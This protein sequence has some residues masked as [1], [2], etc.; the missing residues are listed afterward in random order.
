MKS[1]LN[2]KKLIAAFPSFGDEKITKKEANDFL[3]FEMSLMIAKKIYPEVEASEAYKLFTAYEVIGNKL[4]NYDKYLLQQARL[5]LSASKSKKYWQEKLSEY[6]K[7]KYSKIRLF[8]IKDDKIIKKDLTGIIYADREKDYLDYILTYKK[9]S[10]VATAKSK[11]RE[12]IKLSLKELEKNAEEMGEKIG[13]DYFIKVLRDNKI[14]DN[15]SHEVNYININ[16]LVN[17]VGMVGA[18]K[19]TLLKIIV[20]TLN[21][22]GKKIVIVTDTV[23]SVIKLYEE[24]KNLGCDVSPLIGKSNRLGHLDKLVGKRAHL[25]NDDLAAYL[26]GDCVIDANDS[27]SENAVSYGNEPCN[28]LFKKRGEN[29]LCP[30]YDICPT[31]LM[32]R[33]ALTRNIVITTEAGLSMTRIMEYNDLYLKY[34]VENVDLVFFDESDRTQKSLDNIFIPETSF[35]AYITSVKDKMYWAWSNLSELTY[36]EYLN[37]ETNLNSLT[38]NFRA[39][40]TDVVRNYCNSAHLKS[41]QRSVS[42]FILLE[43]LHEKGK[44]KITDKSY[45][46]MRKLIYY[47]Q[48]VTSELFS[49]M[50]LVNSYNNRRVFYERLEAWISINEPTAS[51]LTKKTIALILVLIAFDNYMREISYM[52]YEMEDKSQMDSELVAFFKNRMLR[53]QGYLPSSP[54]GNLFG[55]T[56]KDNG[57]IILYR[58]YAYGRAL[59]TELPYLRVNE[60]G[61]YTGPHVVLLSGSSYAKGSYSYHVN[62]DVSYII[63]ASHEIREYISKAEFTELG[64]S[65][66][67][68]G[69]A[70][71]ERIAKLQELTK[72]IYDVILDEAKK[73]GKVL[74]VVNSYEQAKKLA[75]YL[76]ELLDKDKQDIGVA[77][78]VSNSD[79]SDNIEFNSIKRDEVSSFSSAEE[80]IL[81]APTLAIERGH[82]IVDE[83]GHAAISSV[84]FMIRPMPVPGSIEDKAAK[85]NG[86]ISELAYENVYSNIFEKNTAIRHGATKFW[87]ILNDS[88]KM[89]LDNITDTRIKKDIVA[90]IFI[91]IVQIFG[92]MCR[93]T[94]TSK[95][96]PRVYFVDGAFRKRE[97]RKEGFDL[98]NE[99]YDYLEDMINDPENGAIAKTLYGPFFE[100]YKKGI[101]RS[102]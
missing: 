87:A 73:E 75:I 40:I 83:N 96:A 10:F 61:E 88:E 8:D 52:Y 4:A 39:Y 65:D 72:K 56:Q 44:E 97:D 3:R 74:L 18:G 67:I 27:S 89:R 60:E 28:R 15:K 2:T 37:I 24:F 6:E 91:L 79:I 90:T 76:Q 102:E 78:L 26:T 33:E 11:K 29:N 50:N 1:I 32:E 70:L 21:K 36:N 17:I 68:S 35:D 93:I 82:N 58:Q 53:Q 14:L 49:I 66:R 16:E 86:Y 57:D 92:R 54:L 38:T 19:S 5:C 69:S 100:S 64:I 59:M 41:L 81:I 99:I 48:S 31:T 9:T 46:E 71:D 84:F 30:H 12:A 43:E 25:L 94:D 63:E 22:M 45:K 95:P 77:A 42:A 34:V 51:N 23:P 62:V 80:K 101:K 13:D 85:V 47:N 20:Y 98:L 55:I 7:E